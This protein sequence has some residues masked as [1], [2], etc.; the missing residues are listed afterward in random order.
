MVGPLADDHR[1]LL[2]AWSAAGN[3]NQSVSVLEGIDQ[4]LGN[5]IQILH[6]KGSNLLEDPY[7]FK[8]LNAYGGDIIID[9]RTATEMIDEAVEAAQKSDVIVAVVGETQ[10]MT[11]EAS[12][13]ADIRLPACQQR[14]LQALFQ[15]W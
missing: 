4:L 15:Y 3:W 7:M 9:N 8:L 5:N 2:G 13:R 6:A 12:S 14:L 10:G 11:G 1:N